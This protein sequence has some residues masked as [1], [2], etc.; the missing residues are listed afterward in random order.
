MTYTEIAELLRWVTKD[1]DGAALTDPVIQRYIVKGQQFIM[2]TLRLTEYQTEKDMTYTADA[3][4]VTIPTDVAWVKHIEIEE[5]DGSRTPLPIMSDDDT[6]G[7]S[8]QGTSYYCWLTGRSLSVR[9]SGEN[10]S[11]ALSLK[12]LCV[13]LLAASDF[14]W[15]DEIGTAD[16]TLPEHHDELLVSYLQWKLRLMTARS[17]WDFTIAREWKSEFFSDLSF[18]INQREGVARLDT[19]YTTTTVK[20]FE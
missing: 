1:V 12:L 19:Q 17:K 9:T 5:D 10:P 20:M 14:D 8:N 11:S 15:T 3:S 4:S 13:P 7:H 18:Y 6:T 2:N 16:D